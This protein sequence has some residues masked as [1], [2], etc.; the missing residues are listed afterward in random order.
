MAGEEQ[1][2]PLRPQLLQQGQGQAHP[3]VVKGAQ[4]VVQQHRRVRHGE[5]AH[6]QPDGQI[7]LLRRPGGQ[8][9]GALGQGHPLPGRLGGKIPGQ[10]EP[11][12]PAPGEGGKQLPRPLVQHRGKALAQLV[13]GRAQ[14]VQGGGEGVVLLQT[15]GQLPVQLPPPGLQILRGP[16]VGQRP[17]RA[18]QLLLHPG[19]LPLHRGQL[20]GGGRL[21]LWRLV[22][23]EQLPPLGGQILHPAAGGLLG[24]PGLPG[25]GQPLPVRRRLGQPVFVLRDGDS[26]DGK[27]LLGPAHQFPPV[28]Q[29]EP[30][31]Q[32]RRTGQS[33][34]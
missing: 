27:D 15:A 7:E 10:G 4:R 18:G 11:V 26:R 33:R 31:G 1:D 21:G 5:P 19:Q 24:G 20:G 12:P 34:Q 13:V 8:G 32:R 17:L 16:H 30:P 28:E 29:A 25:L 22:G 2:L 14:R 23:V 9:Q 6:R 3:L